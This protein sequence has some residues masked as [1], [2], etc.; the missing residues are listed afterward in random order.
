MQAVDTHEG[1]RKSSG[2]VSAPFFVFPAQIPLKKK[3]K[4]SCQDQ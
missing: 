2:I 4:T 1:F 3:L